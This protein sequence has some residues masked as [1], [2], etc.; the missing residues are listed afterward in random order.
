ML[1][2]VCI[3]LLHIYAAAGRTVREVCLRNIHIHADNVVKAQILVN[4][5]CRY[6]SGC[7]GPDY[8][9]GPVTQSPPA[10]TPGAC[11]TALQLAA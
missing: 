4:I 1:S 11:S 7:N 2:L 9:A 10:N 6:L 5:G 8:S 3:P